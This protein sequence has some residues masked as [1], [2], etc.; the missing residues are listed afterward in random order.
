MTLFLST[1]ITGFEDIVNEILPQLLHG[2]KIKDSYDGIVVYEYKGNTRDI[3]SVAVFNNT[4]HL[5]REFKGHS[6]AFSTM[7]SSIVAKPC[8]YLPS[9]KHSTFRIRFFQENQTVKVP[10]NILAKAEDVIVHATNHRVNRLGGNTEF[11]YTIRRENVAF[12]M[13]LLFQRKH[14]EKNLNKGELRPEFAYLMCH[15]A[16]IK[17]NDIVYD[18]FAGFGAIP[19][20]IIQHFSYGSLMVSDNDREKIKEFRKK[21]ICQNTKVKLFFCDA[22]VFDR[23]PDHSVDVIVT[24]PPWGYYENIEDIQEFYISMLRSMS[25]IIKQSGEL[26]ILSARKTEFETAVTQSQFKIIRKLDVLVN[27]KKAGIYRLCFM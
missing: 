19:A 12:Y 20:Q 3:E 22:L 23:I 9:A 15:V 11:W 7:L 4:F 14:T 25:R 8:N 18:P 13:Q 26:V 1:Y 16:N 10:A 21:S 6:I 24:D 27:G 2:V 17:P 5:L